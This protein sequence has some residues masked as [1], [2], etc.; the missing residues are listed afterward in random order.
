MVPFHC[1]KRVAHGGSLNQIA[2]F[3][4]LGIRTDTI[5]A[6]LEED[7]VATI[8]PNAIGVAPGG[9]GGSDV[10]REVRTLA[11]YLTQFLER[12]DFLFTQVRTCM[13]SCK[14]QQQA[15]RLPAGGALL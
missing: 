1:E 12:A 4:A 15:L 10:L 5:R 14:T 6:I 9:R 3:S 7:E 2:P 11:R 8:I 13:R